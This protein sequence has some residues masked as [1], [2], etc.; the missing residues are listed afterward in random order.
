[1][2]AASGTYF[3]SIVNTVTGLVDAVFVFNILFDSFVV[4]TVNPKTL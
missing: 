4:A 1:M 3:L 2:T